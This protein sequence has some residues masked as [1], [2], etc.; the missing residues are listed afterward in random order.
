MTRLV[1][2]LAVL[3][4]IVLLAALMWWGYRGRARRQAAVLPEFPAVPDGLLDKARSG[5]LATLLPP[6]TGVYAST[7]T[8]AGWQDRVGLHQLY[9]VAVHA[10]LFGGGYLGRTRDL[11]HTW[12]GA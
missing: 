3:A 9:P 11:L 5:E 1:L 2:T 12:A 7:V 8:D 6:S 4:V 10:A